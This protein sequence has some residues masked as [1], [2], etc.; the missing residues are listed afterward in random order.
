VVESRARLVGRYVLLGAC[1]VLGGLVGL[2]RLK[3]NTPE[4]RA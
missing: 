3:S 2:S 4:L 1:L